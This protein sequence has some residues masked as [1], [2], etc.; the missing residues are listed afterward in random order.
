MIKK[1]LITLMLVLALCFNSM[2]KFEEFAICTNFDATALVYTYY[3]QNVGG[4]AAT[5]GQIEVPHVKYMTVGVNLATLN[6]T[7]IAVLIQAKINGTWYDVYEKVYAATDNETIVV[8]ET[9]SHIRIGLKVV[10]DAQDDDITIGLSTIRE[11][12]N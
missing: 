7:S 8:T 5:S 10:A 11:I 12:V 2:A 9:C 1:I 3:L 4:V 6:S